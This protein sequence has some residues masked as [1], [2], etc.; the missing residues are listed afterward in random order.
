MSAR[1]LRGAA[2]SSARC[3][4]ADSFWPCADH[5]PASRSRFHL[6]HAV[7]GDLVQNDGPEGSVEHR[8]RVTVARS[9]PRVQFSV[10]AQTDGHE[11]LKRDIRLP[12]DAV[13]AVENPRSRA[14]MSFA[15]CLF[16]VSVVAR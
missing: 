16:A 11:R 15:C 7:W 5:F 3:S 6:L 4:S 2:A 12:A 9:A 14:S 13:A 10:I 8:N 1:S